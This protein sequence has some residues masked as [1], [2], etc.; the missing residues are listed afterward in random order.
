MSKSF[1]PIVSHSRLVINPFCVVNDTSM[2]ARSPDNVWISP[3][4]AWILDSRLVT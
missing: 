3:A 4:L 1:T 2:A